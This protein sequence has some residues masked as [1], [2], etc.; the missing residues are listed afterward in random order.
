MGHGCFGVS[1]IYTKYLVLLILV[2]ADGKL[3][4]SYVPR[5]WSA[6]N[7]V[8]YSERAALFEDL[9]CLAY[10]QVMQRSHCPELFDSA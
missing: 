4:I 9:S 1:G 5:V 7:C 8:T 6:F 10:P 3:E 2:V